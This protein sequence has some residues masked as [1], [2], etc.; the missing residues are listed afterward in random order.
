MRID[1]LLLIGVVLLTATAGQAL[2][3]LF[4]GG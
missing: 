3:A 1:P 2:V 4:C